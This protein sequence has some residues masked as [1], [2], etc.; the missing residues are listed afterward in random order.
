M[1]EEPNRWEGVYPNKRAEA[2]W[3]EDRSQVSLDLI[4]ASQSLVHIM[5]SPIIIPLLLNAIGRMSCPKA[6]R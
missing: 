2:S 1:A 4:A 6:R 5:L 3:F